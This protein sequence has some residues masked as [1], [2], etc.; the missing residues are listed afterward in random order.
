M[1]QS[2]ETNNNFDHIAFI[3]LGMMGYPMAGRLATAGYPLSVFDINP[4]ASERFGTEFHCCVCPSALQAAQNSDVVITMLPSS[5]DVFASVHGQESSPGVMNVLKP[6]ATIIDMSSCDPFQTGHLAGILAERGITFVDAPVSGGV[7]RAQEGALTVMFGGASESLERSRPIL[8]KMGS[9]IYH[10]GAVGTGH[11]MKALN[12][13]VSAAGLLAVVEALHTGKK[14]GLD[15]SVMT[16][17]LNG[18]TGRN[19]TTEKKVEQF[20][21][22]EKFNSGFSL[23]LMVKDIAIAMNLAKDLQIP[24]PLGEACLGTWRNAAIGSDSSVDHTEM[25]RILGSK[26]THIDP[27]D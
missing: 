26:S 3:G 2:M 8:E 21:L 11:A 17:I 6:G 4:C 15:P 5:E 27:E 7:K 1:D 13:Y 19:N 24:T 23:Q 25:Y 22:S 14:F 18:S 12:N 20:M 10:T 9:L 16:L